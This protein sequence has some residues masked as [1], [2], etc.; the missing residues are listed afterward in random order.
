MENV[1]SVE[2][3][4]TDR[5]WIQQYLDINNEVWY[6]TREDV[7]NVGL[8]REEIIDLTRDGMIAHGKKEYE[9]PA[10]IGVH[11]LPEV[12][13]HAMPA[14]VPSKN[15]VGCK[16]IECYPLNK[17]RFNL[18]QTT[19][20]LIIN[21]V[22]SG[23]P[24]AIMDCAWVTAMRTPAVTALSV[25]A[26]H[27]Y[28]TTY[29]QFG[30]GVQGVE[31]IRYV[32]RTMPKIKAFYIY[33]IY[34]E[35]MDNLIKNVQPEIDAKIIKCKSVEEAV[36]SAEVLS[37]ATF[38]VK[39]PMKIIRDEWISKGQTVLPC[40]LNTYLDP[41]T[42]ERAD[43]YIVDSTSEHELFAGAGYFPAGLPA[44]T[45]ETGEILAGLKP[46]R[47]NKDQLIVCSNIGISVNDVVVG[48]ELFN[49]G[50]VKNIGRKMPL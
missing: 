49:R 45:C 35:S 14:Y 6:M 3:D 10:K 12:F 42:I 7:V 5:K 19:G 34:E 1:K 31:H 8:T 30:C 15:A 43:K 36:K 18:D 47:D 50:V 29:A 38:I 41:A 40:D 37:S 16:W 9:M 44:I 4:L 26:L 23:C 17:E 22:Y 48:R 25:A 39:E 46:G 24:I 21:D 2:L 28:A 11:L 33:D 32:S 27:P 13:F 20:L